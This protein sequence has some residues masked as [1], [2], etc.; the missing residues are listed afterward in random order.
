MAD[1]T[2]FK[3]G[4]LTLTKYSLVFLFILAWALVGVSLGVKKR[5]EQVIDDS[6]ADF[7]FTPQNVSNFNP[8]VMFCGPGSL[9]ENAEASVSGISL[10]S[11]HSNLNLG[12]IVDTS[13]PPENVA[14]VTSCPGEQVLNRCEEYTIPILFGLI[15]KVYE[16]AESDDSKN[17]FCPG[18][19]Q[20]ADYETWCDS[21]HVLT[22]LDDS[23]DD[24]NQRNKLIRKCC[25]DP[26]GDDSLFDIT[27]VI[28][29]LLITTPI[30]VVAVYKVLQQT[31]LK[32]KDV[33]N[34][35]LIHI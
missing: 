32:S 28:L 2:G 24:S 26:P 7:E 25:K 19:K 29:Y 10:G 15:G 9:S 13:A 16:G 18:D 31:Y 8:D 30:L 23:L 1:D 6:S 20:Y 4:I 34:L 14:S 35:S 17:D 27:K 5:I 3:E 12:A 21:T 11:I 33:K 22:S